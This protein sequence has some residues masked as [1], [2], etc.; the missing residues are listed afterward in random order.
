[1]KLCVEIYMKHQREWEHLQDEC[2]VTEDIRTKFADEHKVQR[3]EW[4]YSVDLLWKD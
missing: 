1:V 4:A 3:N 2:E